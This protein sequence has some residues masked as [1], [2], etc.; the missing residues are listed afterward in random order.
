MVRRFLPSDHQQGFRQNLVATD[1]K[2]YSLKLICRHRFR[3]GWR[4]FHLF[5]LLNLFGHLQLNC[6]NFWI[7]PL[8]LRASTT[9]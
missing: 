1:H 9:P 7:L 2:Q 3:Q 5:Q 4:E 6:Q 8:T